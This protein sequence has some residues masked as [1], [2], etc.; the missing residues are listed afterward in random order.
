MLEQPYSELSDFSKRVLKEHHYSSKK[1]NRIE[2]KIAQLK[3]GESVDHIGNFAVVECP[4]GQFMVIEVN[5]KIANNLRQFCD[6]SFYTVSLA[7]LE[8]KNLNYLT[9]N[10]L[11][12]R[13]NTWY[14]DRSIDIESFFE[15][16]SSFIFEDNNFFQ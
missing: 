14:N 9:L 10:D 13:F 16:T 2:T 4:S 7:D 3:P 8:I 1:E 15:D 6:V 5:Y 11:M 12:P